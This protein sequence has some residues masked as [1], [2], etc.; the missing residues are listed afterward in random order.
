MLSWVFTE[1]MLFPVR[2]LDSM[3]QMAARHQGF[4]ICGNLVNDPVAIYNPAYPNF[5][6]GFWNRSGMEL[7]PTGVGLGFKVSP[8]ATCFKVANK[9]D[10]S[11]Q[12]VQR[13]KI[14]TI[15]RFHRQ[16]D[17]KLL[18][19]AL[20]SLIAQ[21]DCRVQPWIALQDLSDHDFGMLQSIVD[22]LPWPIDC[23]PIYRRYFST[24]DNPDLRSLMLNETLKAVGNGYLTFLDYDDIMFP[25][26]YGYLASRLEQTH[27]NAAFGRVYTATVSEN[28]LVINREVEFIAGHSYK[29][30]LLRN[31]APLHSFMLNLDRID[32]SQITYHPG[33]KYM[34]DYFLTLQIFGEEC[35]DWGS[36]DEERF[37]GDYKH[38]QGCDNHTLALID[39]S[40]KKALLHLDSYM[41]C[42]AWIVKMRR[43][44]MMADSKSQR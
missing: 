9:A 1:A 22:G 44:V 2:A 40:K 14:S 38:R 12:L 37:I 8:D 41:A 17:I 23:A 39:K 19:D 43:Q 27:K 25:D 29:E 16:G 28:A 4:C 20:L 3:L 42:E 31:H 30:F 26:A 35:T 11:G 10:Y 36:L 21:A 32:L 18:V 7:R 5:S 33:M 13:R 6:V 24:S 15:I 34:E